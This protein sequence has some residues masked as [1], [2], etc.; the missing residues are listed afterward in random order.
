[1][2]HSQVKGEGLKM[3][4]TL[5]NYTKD[6]IK[7]I[8]DAIRISG[9]FFDKMTDE[10]LVKYMVK[11]DY[12]S[13]LEHISF[14]FLLKDISVALSRELLEHR[15]ASHTAK[16]TRYVSQADELP[17]YMPPKIKN[18]EKQMLQDAVEHHL[19]R[20]HAL[21]KW[22]EQEVDRES[23]RYFLPMGL[24]CTYT[25]T[26]NSR[27][28]INFF[29]LRLCHCAAPEMQE[30]ARKVY[31]FAAYIYPD[32]FRDVW[33]RGV[34]TGVCPEPKG[35]ACGKM[36]RLSEM[37]KKVYGPMEIC[38]DCRVKEGVRDSPISL[39]DFVNCKLCGQVFGR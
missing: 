11:H 25:W 31:F 21:Y 34:T 26:I 13:T 33:C 38:E 35:R 27:S 5:E 3:K 19:E 17:F 32:I 14:T 2:I 6:G 30:L 16:S 4:V 18:H 15:I 24:L 10:E 37:R 36:P 22:I 12:G 1:M 20:T 23:A 7:T 39:C 9:P 29:G 28:L 8:A